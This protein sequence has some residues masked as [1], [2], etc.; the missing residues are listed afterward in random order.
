MTTTLIIIRHGETF[1]NRERRIQGHLDSALTP[2]G[3]AQAQACATRLATE[4]I[5]AVVVSDLNR[6]Q[7][8]AKILIAG[9][10][11]SMTADA[12]LRERCFGAGEGMTYADM[13]TKYPQMFAQTGLVDAEFTLPD[14][15]TRADFHARVKT[16]IEKLAVAHAG[17]CLLIVTHGGV[18]GVIYRW[19][20]EMPIASA[21]RVAIPNVAYNRISIQP[22]GW[23]IDVWAD[24][25][26]LVD[27]TVE[28]G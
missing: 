24:T 10:A 17:K 5:D 9:R 20:N 21:Q 3:I 8:T 1:W 28:D 26:H 12:T 11:L 23:K 7:H 14:G 13:D 2:E 4:K 19:L 18:L 27:H 25:S 22:D 16:S 15:E 6:A